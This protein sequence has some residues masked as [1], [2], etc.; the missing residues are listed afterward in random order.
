MAHESKK[1]KHSRQ[2]DLI[3]NVVRSSRSHPTANWIYEKVKAI[4]PDISLGTVYRNLKILRDA[5]KIREF[6]IGKDVR[7]YDG[8]MRE[9][10]HVKCTE[11]GC[12]EDIP[13]IYSDEY[14]REIEEKTGFRIFRLRTEYFGICLKCRNKTLVFGEIREKSGGEHEKNDR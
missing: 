7:C 11:C 14:I 8:D 10:S 4:K 6:R 2:R 5:G 13:F 12:I 3:L 1:L 9:H